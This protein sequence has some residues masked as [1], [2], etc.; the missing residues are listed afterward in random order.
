MEVGPTTNGLG[1]NTPLE[2][3]GPKEAVGGVEVG[4]TTNG[5]GPNIPELEPF[6]PGLTHDVVLEPGFII[7]GVSSTAG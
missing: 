7:Q 2:P 1:P 5:L 3:L 4:P 6:E